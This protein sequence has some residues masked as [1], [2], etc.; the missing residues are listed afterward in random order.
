MNNKNSKSNTR[1]QNSRHLT[2]ASPIRR[3]TRLAAI[4]STKSPKSIEDHRPLESADIGDEDETE[5]GGLSIDI[6]TDPEDKERYVFSRW[7]PVFHN[8]L[9]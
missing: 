9:G 8:V 3:S 6:T 5:V 4:N 2:S 7:F 1:H